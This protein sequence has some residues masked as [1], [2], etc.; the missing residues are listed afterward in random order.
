MLFFTFFPFFRFEFAEVPMYEANRAVFAAFRFRFSVRR[1]REFLVFVFLLIYFP[2]SFS[3]PKCTRIL[4]H[5]SRKIGALI[6]FALYRVDNRTT[7]ITRLKSMNLG[8]ILS[9][10]LNLRVITNGN[11]VIV[12]SIHVISF[13]SLA[14][15]F[16][17]LDVRSLRLFTWRSEFLFTVESEG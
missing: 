11:A 8:R 10:I 9:R 7:S 4:L 12:R 6:L 1:R 3:K 2:F 14:S 5:F 17:W 13:L 16:F 15:G